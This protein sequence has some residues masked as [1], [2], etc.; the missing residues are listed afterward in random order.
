VTPKTLLKASVPTRLRG[1]DHTYAAGTWCWAIKIYAEV[2]GTLATAFDQPLLEKYCLLEE[3]VIELEKLRKTIRE[4]WE[5][6]SKAAKKIKPNADTLKDWVAMWNVV[7]ALFQR[8]QGIDARLDG[9][10]KLL[11]SISQ[12]L[13]LTP[14]SRAGVAPTE[15]EQQKDDDPMAQLLDS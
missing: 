9:K 11:H 10:V 8:F 4:D 14:R 3:Q 13:Y 7:N 15:K 2:E 6:S 12:S 5:S 1:R